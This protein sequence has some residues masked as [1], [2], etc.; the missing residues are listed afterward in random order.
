[1]PGLPLRTGLKL[2]A[3]CECNSSLV[4]GQMLNCAGGRSGGGGTLDAS[5]D[6]TLIR[7]TTSARVVRSVPTCTCAWCRGN[8]SH[9]VRDTE[10]R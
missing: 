2:T 1:M 4:G 7:R 10:A 9:I 3:T 5:T 6:A 8:R